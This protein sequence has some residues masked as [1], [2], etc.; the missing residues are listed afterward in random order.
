MPYSEGAA[1]G[2]VQPGWCGLHL[3]S[4]SK[5]NRKRTPRNPTPAKLGDVS[6]FTRLS[7]TLLAA[8]NVLQKRRLIA[9]F[10]RTLGSHVGKPPTSAID[11]ADLSPRLRETLKHL[12]AGDSEQ[13]IAAKRGLSRHTVHVYVKGLYKHF[14][15]YSRGELLAKCLRS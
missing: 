8:D 14:N 12:L 13:Q 11:A 6:A 1:G 15:V 10:F 3:H 4:L 9:D 5:V 2:L 7:R